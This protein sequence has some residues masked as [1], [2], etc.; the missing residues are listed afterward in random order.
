MESQV[1]SQ[2]LSAYVVSLSPN[3]AQLYHQTLAFAQHTDSSGTR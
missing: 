2:V 1:Q 3:S